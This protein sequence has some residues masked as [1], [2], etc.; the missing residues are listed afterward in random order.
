MHSAVH[1]AN[2][3]LAALAALEHNGPV[4]SGE[5]LVPGLWVDLDTS[6]GAGDVMAESGGGLLRLTL[7]P[8]KAGRWCT[9]NI[10]LGNTR[11]DG[12]ALLG[13]AIRS[14]APRSTT[15]RLAVRSFLP[16]GGMHDSFFGDHLVAFGTESTH[17]DVLWLAHEPVLRAEADWRTLLLFFDPE[18]FD[19]SILDMRLFAA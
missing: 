16:G 4:P 3:A 5:R 1:A 6:G 8:R 7:A 15:A 2:S 10:D 14:R 12:A 13:V 19:I 11:R 17:C 9:L 18:G